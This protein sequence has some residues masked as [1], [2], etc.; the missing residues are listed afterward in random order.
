MKLPSGVKLS[1]PLTACP[2]AGIKPHAS[3]I[4]GSKWS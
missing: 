1:G 4:S 2:S 3:F